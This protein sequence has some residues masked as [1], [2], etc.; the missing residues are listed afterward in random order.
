MIFES[1]KKSMVFAASELLGM[2]L[3]H[4]KQSPSFPSI[5]DKV[6]E[7]LKSLEAKD[8]HDIYVFSIERISREYHYLLEDP[9]IF[10]KSLSYVKN[11]TGQMRGSVFTS[12]ERHVQTQRKKNKLENISMIC[13]SI[14]SDNRDILTDINDEN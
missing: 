13:K 12:I 8:K 11:L 3:N 1:S 6:K 5:L 14:Q 10:Q 9:R 2:V 7:M 4:H